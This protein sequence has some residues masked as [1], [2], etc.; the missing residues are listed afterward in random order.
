[1]SELEDIVTRLQVQLEGLKT[2]TIRDYNEVLND[3]AR[4]LADETSGRELSDMTR[5]QIEGLVTRVRSSHQP[6]ADAALAVLLDVLRDLAGY[7]Y[8]FEAGAIVAGSTVTSVPNESPLRRVWTSVVQRPMG[9]DGSLLMP[10]LDRLTTAQVSATENLIRRAYVEGWSNRDMLQAFRGTRANRYTDGIQST[11][12]RASRT[13]INTAMQHVNSAARAVVWEEN[14]DIVQGYR[15]VATLDSRTTEECRALD[16]REFKLGDGPMPPLHMNCRSTTVA[17]LDPVFDELRSRMTR[18]SATGPVP[19]TMTY[20]DWLKGQSAAFQDKVLGLARGKLFRD[21]G[22]SAS[23]FAR[24]QLN[25]FFE[26]LTLEEM[27]RLKPLAFERAG[28]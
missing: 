9:H 16:G 27:R 24:L 8:E 5:R 14:E 12:G 10:F 2:N 19:Q 18:A 21:G 11:L 6:N 20:Y 17:V 13:I 3:L 23:E 7:A 22:L 26:P 28:I 1:M 15:I 4:V 25:K